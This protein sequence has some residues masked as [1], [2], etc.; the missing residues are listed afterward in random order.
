M[1]FFKKREVEVDDSEEVAITEA[2]Q[3]TKDMLC[4]WG[5]E[6]GYTSNRK[7]GSL[8][9][10]ECYTFPWYETKIIFSSDSQRGWVYYPSGVIWAWDDE[11]EGRRVMLHLMADALECL[12]VE[13]GWTVTE[14]GNRGRIYQAVGFELFNLRMNLPS[15]Y[16]DP[17]CE[18]LYKEIGSPREGV[19]VEEMLGIFAASRMEKEAK[20]DD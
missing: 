18:K 7:T 3:Q 15:F 16:D 1:R 19:T 20:D 5:W 12:A 11:H 9:L 2:R 4:K 10:T 13:S 8:G 17:V 14:E 6:P